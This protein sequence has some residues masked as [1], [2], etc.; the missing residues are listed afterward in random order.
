[1]SE[2]VKLYGDDGY[3]GEWPE[4]YIRKGINQRVEFEGDEAVVETMVDMINVLLEKGVFDLDDVNRI[5]C[6][7]DGEEVVRDE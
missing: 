3:R 4:N 6:R 2:K 5:V 7:H 1:M